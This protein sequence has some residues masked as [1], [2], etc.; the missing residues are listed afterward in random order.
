M[1]TPFVW[2]AGE[3]Q[4]VLV[5]VFNMDNVTVQAHIAEVGVHKA[6]SAGRVES[7][8]KNMREWAIAC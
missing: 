7:R 5:N 8:G 2:N 6:R 4:T 1:S 3:S